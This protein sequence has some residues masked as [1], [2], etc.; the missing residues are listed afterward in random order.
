MHPV[1]FKR[2]TRK[3]MSKYPN[4]FAVK[5]CFVRNLALKEAF[6]QDL[7]FSLATLWFYGSTYQLRITTSTGY[8]NL[9]IATSGAELLSDFFLVAKGVDIT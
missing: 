6:R 2:K 8:R 4:I 3:N 9:A 1:G 7:S 5:G